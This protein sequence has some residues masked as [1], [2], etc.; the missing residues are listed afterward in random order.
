MTSGW[1]VSTRC[2]TSM[3]HT[4]AELLNHG[5]E[6]RFDNPLIGGHQ[7]KAVNA[8]CRHDCPVGGIAERIAQRHHLGSD[9][10]IKR[11]NL[12]SGICVESF[13]KFLRGVPQAG[14]TFAEQHCYFKQTDG[15]YG[16]RF[17]ALDRATKHTTLLS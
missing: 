1:A 16:E 5:H 3:R 6:F 4:A 9:F 13:E 14:S 10:D 17:A 7:P 12:Q 11:D 2:S 8:R 15:A